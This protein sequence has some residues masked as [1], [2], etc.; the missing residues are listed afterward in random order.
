MTGTP[1]SQE[2][3]D[4]VRQTQPFPLRPFHR[5]GKSLPDKSIGMI[6]GHMLVCSRSMLLNFKLVLNVRLTPPFFFFYH[7]SL[8]KVFIKK[9]S[10]LKDP[11]HLKFYQVD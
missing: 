1:Q 10:V 6:Q 8:L 9:K 3:L 4:S 5:W 2:G 7:F 11:E